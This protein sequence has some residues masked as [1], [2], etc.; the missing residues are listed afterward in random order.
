MTRTD[1][2][3][4]ESPSV[5]TYRNRVASRAQLS[6]ADA[7]RLVRT[8]FGLSA[9]RAEALDGYDDRNFKVHIEGGTLVLLKAHNGVDSAF[10]NLIEAQASL[11][12][13]LEE[14]GLPFETPRPYRTTDRAKEGEEATE[15]VV[16]PTLSVARG[17]PRPIAL[18]VT[19]FVDGEIMS[20]EALQDHPRLAHRLGATV[21]TLGDAL[22]STPLGQ[23]EE[24]PNGLVR[25]NLIWDLARFSELRSYAQAYLEGSRQALVLSVIDHFDE[26]VTRDSGDFPRAI[27]HGDFNNGNL[28]VGDTDSGHITGVI[29]FGDTVW[30]YRV[31]EVAIA[32]AYAMI[33]AGPSKA[34]E[35]AAEVLRGFEAHARSPLTT[36]ER[37]HLRAL[38]AARLAQSATLGAFSVAMQPENAKYLAL[39][40][41]PAWAVLTY[42]WQQ[43]D[44]VD[45]KTQ[46]GS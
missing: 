19:S 39:H 42:L 33:N 37:A 14:V 21:A 6:E 15:F 23:A 20:A 29:D 25:P 27:I 3:T 26:V 2:P 12:A 1:D 16:R 32:L 28:I 43:T 10:P 13:Q 9:T 40:S 4:H 36:T 35:T 45:W 30:S 31:A 34:L 17:E 44:A 22:A 8:Y 7:V 11:L 38:S 41:E 5:H 46:T 24:G 18:R